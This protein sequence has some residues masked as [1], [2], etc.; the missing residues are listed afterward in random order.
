MASLTMIESP[1]SIAIIDAVDDKPPPY[2][3]DAE[4]PL[5]P[6]KTDVDVEM[7]IIDT[8]PITAKVTT[9]IGHLNRVGGFFARWRGLPLSFLYHFLHAT[10]TNLI[11]GV[12]GLG[13]FG[14]ALVYILVSLGLAR[15]HMLWTHSMIAHPSTKPFWRRI[16]SRKQ[17]KAI[18]LPSLV[19]AVAQQATF[20]IP[21]LMAVFFGLPD[22]QMTTL[23]EAMR[24]QEW[25][26][27]ILPALFM[28]TIS[29]TGI[30]LVLHLLLP[31]AVTLTRIE[32]VLLSEGE[33]TIV[34]FDRESLMGD[35][36]LSVR[37]GCKTLFVR[38]WRSFDRAARWRLIKVYVKMVMMQFT[39]GLVGL[40]LMVAEL[41]IIGGDRLGVL[42]KSAAAQLKLMAIEA[43]QK[44]E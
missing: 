14:G 40:H 34:P 41:Y 19:F 36:D 38:V 22:Q 13:I 25:N 39:V 11:A 6:S 43:H 12:L 33:E 24:N 26:K 5:E 8:K 20:L 42:F 37:G 31:A 30:F 7:T 3:D 17:S 29:I 1:S 23:C 27:V 32:A 10:F 35:T 44:A 18:L 4:T 15:V 9:T 2:T 21:L 28:L 16:V